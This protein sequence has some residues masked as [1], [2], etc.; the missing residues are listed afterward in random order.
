MPAPTERTLVRSRLSGVVGAV[1]AFGA[2]TALA[3]PLEGEKPIELPDWV[4]LDAEYRVQSIVIS[5]LDPSSA[6]IDLV[7][8]TEQRA[9]LD[10]GFRYPGIGGVYAQLDLLDGVL[11]GDNGTYGEVPSPNSGLAVS[12]K[13][14]NNAGWE[15][16]LTESADP[17]AMDS[18][19]PRLRSI[20]PIKIT[21]LYGEAIL[22]FGLLR[23]GRMTMNE[24]A[25]IA[26]HEGNR[27]N[28]WGVSRYPDV[29]DRVLFATKI[30]EAV[31]VLS[32]KNH[33]LDPS[34]KNGVIFAQTYDWNVQDRVT[35]QSDDAYQ[36]NTLLSWRVEKAEWGGV[37]WRDF[38]LGL[39]FVQKYHEAFD[40]Q[41]FAL[42]L[43][44]ESKVGPAEFRILFSPIFG[45]SREVAEGIAVLSGRKPS[46]QDF[47]Q[48]GLHGWFAWDVGPVQ[49]GLEVD[50]ASGDA[51]PRSTTPLTGFSFSRDFNVGLL[52]FEHVLA[53]QTARSAAVGIENLSQLDAK[54]FPLTEI[55]SQ[56]KF[57]SA[58]GIFPQVKWDVVK[59]PKHWFH[60]RLGALFAF[61][62][63][64][65]VDPI[66]TA[67][68]EDGVEVED[69]AQNYYGG[70]PGTYYGTEIDLQLNWTLN[71]FFGW[72]IEAAAVIPGDALEDQHGD[73]LP[74][75][76]FENRFVFAF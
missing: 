29:A 19:V 10:L 16:G 66:G 59:G 7:S 71:G 22:P 40:T 52:L 20:E 69:D 8:W 18:Y 62:P 44:F 56:G 41:V 67:L 57:A 76:L 50:Y 5:G 38:Q 73:A 47:K 23:V 1:M 55:A 37:P 34:V 12:S 70:A 15:L 42:P 53:F 51:D 14:P 27:T 21:H 39:T 11:F 43:R 25:G 28:R 4:K 26:G 48:F 61:A 68:R 33:K 54:S 63:D 30:D 24:G 58:L 31:R 49:I 60:I 2:S 75:F 46:T 74:S 36:L 6:D 64:G 35:S 3:G 45:E 9:R 17:L 32:D 65:S 72:T 13:N